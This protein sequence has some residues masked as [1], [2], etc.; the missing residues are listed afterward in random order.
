MPVVVNPDARL[1]TGGFP[2]WVTIKVVVVVRVNLPFVPEIVRG[3]VPTG[4]EALVAT[5]SVED[6]EVV[7]EEGLNVAVA[8]VGKPVL[9]LNVTAPVK[10][11][12]GVTVV[13]NGALLPAAIDC[14]PGDVPS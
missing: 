8:P 14:E 3:Y 10:P 4:V 1:I 9:T 5:V 6:P 2:P 13:V 12:D 7:T 11:F